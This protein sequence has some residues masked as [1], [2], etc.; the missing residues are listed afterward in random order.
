MIIS[1]IITIKDKL[2]I[3]ILKPASKYLE[4]FGV[5][6]SLYEFLNILKREIVLSYKE[7]YCTQL[8]KDF[9]Q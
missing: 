8:A 9:K 2:I 4:N 3:C 7:L 5:H 1:I 6:S